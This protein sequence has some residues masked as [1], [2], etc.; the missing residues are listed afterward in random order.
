MIRFFFQVMWNVLQK[1]SKLGSIS[2]TGKTVAKAS[3]NRSL[4]DY[5]ETV[6]PNLFCS[7]WHQLSK[8]LNLS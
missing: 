5:V 4:G 2:R 3:Q 7:K 6:P 1:F 8:F